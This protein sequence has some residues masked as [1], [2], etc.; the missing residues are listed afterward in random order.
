MPS[1]SSPHLSA[2]PPTSEREADSSSG[3]ADLCISRP[4]FSLL[5]SGPISSE[6]KLGAKRTS[7]R[8]RLE[9]RSAF[10]VSGTQSPVCERPARFWAGSHLGQEAALGGVG[11]I[12]KPPLRA[13]CRGSRPPSPL[14]PR[15]ED[16]VS[17]C[18]ATPRLPSSSVLPHQ[19]PL[20]WPPALEWRSRKGE[21][22]HA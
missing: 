13:G 22:D 17:V 6:A 11:W 9:V 1:P 21:A 20:P 15:P 3:S 14:L 7:L 4:Q 18:Q 19:V 2:A 12:S 5:G 16:K 8:A 10:F